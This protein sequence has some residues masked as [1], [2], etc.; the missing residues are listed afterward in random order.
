MIQ[1]TKE[2]SPEIY[3]MI[4]TAIKKVIKVEVHAYDLH[5]NLDLFLKNID[6]L[7]LE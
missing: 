5:L 2:E 7:F 6:L 1:Q 4:F 3:N